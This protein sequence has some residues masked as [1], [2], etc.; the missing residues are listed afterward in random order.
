[1]LDAGKLG[2]G[3]LGILIGFTLCA[4]VLTQ[5]ARF[6]R[7]GLLEPDGRASTVLETVDRF[8]A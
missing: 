3:A 8:L 5:N 4:D 7:T 1:M 2:Y 6:P